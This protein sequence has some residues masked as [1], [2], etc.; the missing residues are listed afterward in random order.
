[1]TDAPDQSNNQLSCIFLFLFLFQT[2]PTAVVQQCTAVTC[3]NGATLTTRSI[4][5]THP[6][7]HLL[8]HPRSLANPHPRLPLQPPLPSDPTSILPHSILLDLL[9]V[10][11]R[12]KTQ[13]DLHRKRRPL[14][15]RPTNTLSRRN[16][17]NMGRDTHA[18]QQRGHPR[19]ASPTRRGGWPRRRRKRHDH[20]LRHLHVPPAPLPYRPARGHLP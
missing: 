17:P 3:S 19:P 20:L 18:S 11:P 9:L 2:T 8:R 16:P 5:P 7:P 4:S 15:P 6:L 13:P 14:L 10:P 12:P 1:M